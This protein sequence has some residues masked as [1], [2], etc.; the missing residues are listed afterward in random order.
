MTAL[1]PEVPD[2]A[3]PGGPAVLE[4]EPDEVARRPSAA[5]WVLVVWMWLLAAAAAVVSVFFLPQYLGPVPFPVSVVIAV[6]TVA[7]LP[8]LVAALVPPFWPVAVTVACWFVPAVWLSLSPNS[9]YG[10][11]VGVTDGQ[12]RTALLLGLGCLTAAATLVLL[13][14]A[15]LPA[16]RPADPDTMGERPHGH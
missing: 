7:G 9:L 16:A 15:R 14:A 10:R 2:P 8:R 3:T 1:P 4:A 6:L 12:W 13:R 5:D 11:P